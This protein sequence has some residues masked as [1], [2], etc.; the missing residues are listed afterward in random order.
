MST[1][2]PADSLPMQV[3]GRNGRF[4]PGQSGNPA[5]RRRGTRNRATNIALALLDGEGEALTRKA[6]EMAHA[7]NETMLKL[8][9]E[10]IIPRARPVPVDP[11]EVERRP[12]A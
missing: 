11:G 4:R 2:P 3:P 8:C 9:L 6:I 10:R 7:G 12:R 1:S 5:G